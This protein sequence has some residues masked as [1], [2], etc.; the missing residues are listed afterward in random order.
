MGLDL[1]GLDTIAPE[2]LFSEV[3]VWFMQQGLKFTECFAQMT[4]ILLVIWFDKSQRA[5]RETDRIDGQN[6]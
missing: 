6:I 1:S 3:A 2:E 5:P 4:L